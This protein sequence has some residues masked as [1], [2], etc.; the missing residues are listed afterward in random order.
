[1]FPQPCLIES[2]ALT[3]LPH[4]DETTPL[5]QKAGCS[6]EDLQNG[7]ASHVIRRVR[8]DHVEAL[9]AYRPIQRAN[10][11]FRVADSI[12]RDIGAREADRPPI[13]IGQENMPL[14]GGLCRGDPNGA[15]PT[16]EVKDVVGGA[17]FEVLDEER[18]ARVQ[19]VGREDS[20]V[21]QER[22][23]LAP[24]EEAELMTC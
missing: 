5:P 15:P 8:S 24:V 14:R 23:Q 6:L 18:R 21:D 9:F 11:C 22:Q 1:M 20:R 3:S 4:N 10:A 17:N 12:A 7:R 16:S 13:D 2:N 19:S